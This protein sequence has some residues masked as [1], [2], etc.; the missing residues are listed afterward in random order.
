MPPAKTGNGPGDG[1]PRISN[2]PTPG[3]GPN[4][5][6]TTR[7]PTSTASIELITNTIMDTASAESY[8]IT[9]MLCQKD[10]PYS[11]THL[12][13]IL[14][15]ITQIPLPVTT[16]VR[17][18][19]FILKKHI[20]CEIAEA[21]ASHLSSKLTQ[22]LVEQITAAIKPSLASIQDA[23]EHLQNSIQQTGT[24]LASTTEGIEH[25]HRMLKDER[26]E[27]EAD[28]KIAADRIDETANELQASVEDCRK[29][30]KVLTPSL[31]T[32]QE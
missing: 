12:S 11:L 14:F 32:T 17:A 16:A 20:V 2:S 25:M 4:T 30:L 1:D 26:E 29:L 5:H 7:N 13:S 18:V 27:K 31:D 21:A 22:Q 10:Q 8:L 6:N 24:S 19:A 3:A 23:S 28:V 15:H 9:K